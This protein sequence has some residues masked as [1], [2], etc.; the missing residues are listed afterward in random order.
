[1]G[2]NIVISKNKCLINPEFEDN[3]LKEFKVKK[4]KIQEHN[5]VGS[6]VVANKN[7][8]LVSREAE[9]KE[10]KEIGK[11]LDLK[12]EIGSVNRGNPYVKSGIIVNS[13]GYII[14]GMTTG[15]EVMRIESA[16]K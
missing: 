5:V 1:M 13:K 16:L 10:L 14:G 3:I 11:T 15:V 4:M 9:D 8:C 6:C 12:A 2:N 7:G